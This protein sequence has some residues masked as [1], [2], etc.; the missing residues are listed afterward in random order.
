[1]SPPPKPKQMSNDF[2]TTDTLKPAPA[3]PYNAKSAGLRSLGYASVQL[4]SGNA[5][6]GV[7]AVGDVV[8]ASATVNG[9]VD[10]VAANQSVLV[11]GV[12]MSATTAPG[13]PVEVAIA[14]VVTVNVQ[15]AVTRGQRLGTST[16]LGRAA[17]FASTAINTVLGK[18]LG[19]NPS[20][21]GTVRCLL[22][23][24]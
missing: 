12:A 2:L 9:A 24:N 11:T 17:G 7:I 6:A 8:V 18:S 4:V 22:T 23:L 16:T 21:A 10:R 15:G 20:G 3:S 13:Q 1:M 5:N 14:G 19:T